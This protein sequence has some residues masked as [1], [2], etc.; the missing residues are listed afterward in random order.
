MI[1]MISNLPL[2]LNDFTPGP[3]GGYLC[4]R[5]GSRRL[6][7]LGGVIAFTGMILASQSKTLSQLMLSFGF[8]TG[9]FSIIQNKI[10]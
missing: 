1:I 10:V 3:F 5:F 4:R 2:I 6:A 9:M 8:L 7:L